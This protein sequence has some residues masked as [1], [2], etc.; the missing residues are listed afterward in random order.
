MT[1]LSV[2]TFKHIL[3]ECADLTEIRN[4]KFEEKSLSSLFRNVS[5]FLTAY[6]KLVYF[7]TLW[8]CCV[9]CFDGVVAVGKNIVV[10]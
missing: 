7:I 8:A 1:F 5:P 6:E 9:N 2:I 4:K 3:P 10:L